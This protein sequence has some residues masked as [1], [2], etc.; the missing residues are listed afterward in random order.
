[1][2]Q[3]AIEI[4]NALE[5]AQQGAR[6]KSILER[7][8]GELFPVALPGFLAAICEALRSAVEGD[9]VLQVPYRPRSVGDFQSYASVGLR[10]LEQLEPCVYRFALEAVP[11]QERQ[12]LKLRPEDLA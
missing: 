7:R 9:E 1:M 12:P 10:Q 3:R 6:A 4:L 11:A 5:A 2:N 8:K